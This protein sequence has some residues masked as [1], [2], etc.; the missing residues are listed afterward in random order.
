MLI[1][2]SVRPVRIL[3]DECPSSIIVRTL[4]SKDADGILRRFP[5]TWKGDRS[6]T[7]QE[8]K[9]LAKLPRNGLTCME[10]KVDI[11]YIQKEA[12]QPPRSSIV[13]NMLRR[14]RENYYIVDDSDFIEDLSGERNDFGPVR[15]QPA[16]RPLPEERPGKEPKLLPDPFA[17]VS[18][19]KD[20]ITG[21]AGVWRLNFILEPKQEPKQDKGKVQ[22]LLTVQDETRSL[23]LFTVL[24]KSLSEQLVFPETTPL[25]RFIRNGVNGHPLLW[26]RLADGEEE[27]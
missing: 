24:F 8:I 1:D 22:W 23:V 25:Q 19:Y 7:P 26:D 3:P 18:C 6:P 11:G 16:R 5:D 12:P 4:A 9:P 10:S 13:E 21:M 20:Q 15:I 27:D 17:T 2:V 14:S